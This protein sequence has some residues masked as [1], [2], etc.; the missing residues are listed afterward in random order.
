MP[1]IT[2]VSAVNR[3][4]L[5][6]PEVIAL[7]ATVAV[8][9]TL[10][11]W[12]PWG[13][14]VT[15]DEIYDV[16][17]G[18]RLVRGLET[19]G[20][21]LFTP[22]PIEEVFGA[23]TR[24]P[25]LGRWMLGIAQRPFDARPR[26]LDVLSLPAARFAPALAFGLN[27]W[28][29]GAMARR[30]VGVWAGL[31]TAFSLATMPRLFAHAHL[32]SLDTFVNLSCTAA[33]MG[34][35]WAV[36]RGADRTSI[37]LAGFLWGLAMLTKI[38]GLLLGVPL[39]LWMVWR[40]RRLA[41]WRWPLWAGVGLATFFIGWPWLWLDPWTRFREYLG[42]ATE[43]MSLHVY[44]AGQVWNDVDT[45]WH[46]PWV[47][48]IATLPLGYLVLA[49]V[50]IVRRAP[51]A[52]SDPWT[53]LV[54]LTLV[55]WLSVFSWPGVPVYD[56]VRLFL[57]AFSAIALC[58][59]WGFEEVRLATATLFPER[60]LLRPFV[61]VAFFEA[62]LV[63]LAAYHPF[64]LS[65]YN[66]AVGGLRGAERLGFEVTYW[67]DAVD[68]PLVTAAVE[69][70]QAASPDATPSIVF[71]PHL[72]PYQASGLALTYSELLAG[73]ADVVGWDPQ[74]PELAAGSRYALVYH[75]RADW[76]QVEP[77]LRG[78]RVIAENRRFG[79]W[80]ARLYELPEPPQPPL[81]PDGTDP[82]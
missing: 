34:L 47:L 28:L 29:V 49:A 55:F 73:D 12:Q 1:S 50:G 75:R 82:S 74:H 30:H 57:P 56:G 5:R 4:L 67:G 40:L 48:T 51:R 13:Y 16:A 31:A 32:A 39:T 80:L 54:L 78:A 3:L 25:P 63:G 7:A 76:D 23:Q 72:A 20:L 6:S 61:A 24:H 69:A 18:K 46:Y 37:A 62:Q 70:A 77:L 9:A 52:W 21:E 45:P 44:Y 68:G 33:V 66:L 35:G 42:T 36:T 10:S 26:D 8:L 71:A 27:I 64:Q 22:R 15:C 41:A 65:Y 14:G 17:C 79:V 53:S 43:R 81:P 2:D 59:G 19:H 60:R 58:V 11:P 38:Q